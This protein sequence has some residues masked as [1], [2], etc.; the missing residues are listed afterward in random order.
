MNEVEWCDLDFLEFYFSSI[1]E[2]EKILELYKLDEV[3]EHSRPSRT[4]EHARLPLQIE[5]NE[6]DVRPSESI[7]LDESKDT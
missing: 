4:N 6:S 3:F 2:I 7:P 1:R 5:N